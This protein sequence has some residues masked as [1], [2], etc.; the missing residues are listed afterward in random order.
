MK[1]ILTALIVIGLVVWG[2]ISFK[3]KKNKDIPDGPTAG[4]MSGPVA[5][6][7]RGGQTL[8]VRHVIMEPTELVDGIN[9]SGSLIPNEEVNLSFETSGRLRHRARLPTFSLRR[10][11]R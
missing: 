8:L 1:K 4:A 11:A 5:A 7:G 10:A 9:I 3:P 2:I 6:L